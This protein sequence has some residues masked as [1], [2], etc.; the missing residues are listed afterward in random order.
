MVSS[1]VR[2]TRSRS[3]WS[4]RCCGRDV[5][6]MRRIIGPGLTPLNSS[7]TMRG[8]R[9]RD[10][11]SRKKV[12]QS[13]RTARRP[14]RPE[15]SAEF[16]RRRQSLMSS[17]PNPTDAARLVSITDE[18]AVKEI[19]GTTVLDLWKVVNNLTRLRPSVPRCD[20]RFGPCEA[21]HL[22]VRRSEA[23]GRGVRRD[24]LRHRDGR[25]PRPD[26]SGQPRRERSRRAR[27]GWHPRRA[28]VRAGCQSVRRAG[29]RARDVSSRA[30]IT[31]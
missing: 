20:L 6:V 26:A 24:G 4:S 9:R 29:V 18:E 14:V 7:R 27:V 30:F 2:W 8:V 16:D 17:K 15:S 21:R 28:A 11:N 23:R 10:D 1:P 13:V 22:R 3:R 5:V 31:S 19:L 25:R 12:Q